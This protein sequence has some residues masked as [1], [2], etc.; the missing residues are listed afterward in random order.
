M[1]VFAA[2][3]GVVWE[4]LVWSLSILNDQMTKATKLCNEYAES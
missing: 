3:L 2:C 4:Q 1:D